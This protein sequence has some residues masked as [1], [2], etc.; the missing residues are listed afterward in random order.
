MDT[1]PSGSIGTSATVIFS[2]FAEF[3]GHAIAG[4]VANAITAIAAR[5]FETTRISASS[6]KGTL[7]ATVQILREIGRL[8]REFGP[9]AYSLARVRV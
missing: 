4:A 7:R 6:I 8:A 5:D 1:S 2:D 9:G 3:Q